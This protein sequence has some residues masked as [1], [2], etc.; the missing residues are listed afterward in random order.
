M[1]FIFI[2]NKN[3]METCENIYLNIEIILKD[4]LSIEKK[5]S[6]LIKLQTL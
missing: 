6:K 5:R 2:S 3:Q 4:V 1:Y